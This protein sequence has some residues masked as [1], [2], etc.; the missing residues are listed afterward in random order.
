MYFFLDRFGGLFADHERKAHIV[1]DGKVRIKSVPFKN[2]PDIS[3]LGAQTS[4]P[5][6]TDIDISTGRCLKTGDTAQCGGLAT[7]RGTQQ[8]Y[9]FSVVDREIDV[10][11]GN[12]LSEGFVQLTDTNFRH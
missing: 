7:A 10:V 1:K 8:A 6:I 5:T 3:V 2:H 9:K 4:H 11:N 12:H